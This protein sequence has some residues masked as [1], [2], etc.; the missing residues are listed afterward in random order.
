MWIT[1]GAFEDYGHYSQAV[2]VSISAP[3][4]VFAGLGKAAGVTDEQHLIPSDH[5]KW[6]SFPICVP[7]CD[8]S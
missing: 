7:A 8:E 3:T 2:S 5:Y 6:V 4:L 1:G